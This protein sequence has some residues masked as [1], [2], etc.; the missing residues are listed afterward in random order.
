M[1]PKTKELSALSVGYRNPE[2][3]ARFDE[4]QAAIFAERKQKIV[5]QLR[6][7]GYLDENGNW[8]FKEPL[9]ADMLP[10]FKADFNH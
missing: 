1:A 8:H 5:T 3:V 6:Q 2:E 7:D 9:P 10:D 4:Q